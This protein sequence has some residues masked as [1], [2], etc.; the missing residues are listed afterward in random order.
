MDTIIV[1]TGATAIG[2]TSY[3]IRYAEEQA[4]EIISADS[5]QVYRHMDIGTAKPSPAELQRVP[6]HLV[7]IIDPDT[8]FSVA[9][10]V[11]RFKEVK[12]LL[13]KQG[14][15]YLVVGGTG[16]YL[17]AL[18]EGFNFPSAVPDNELRQELQD[19]VKKHDA[20]WL[21]NK[22]KELDP[23][24]AERLHP[25]DHFRLIRALEVVTATGKPL[26]EQQQKRTP[27]VGNY[28]LLCLTAPREVIYERINRRVDEMF[29]RGLVEEVQKLLAM[30]YNKNLMSLQALGYKETI[31]HLAGKY[32]RDELIELVKKRT[33]NFAKRQ[34]TWFRSFRGLEYIEIQ[35]I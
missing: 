6:H 3:A 34:M 13:E 26:A 9:D 15:N 24:T 11:E 17:R 29:S 27:L 21:H 1:I 8:P 32:G 19:G 25:N 7:N 4:A 18:L 20:N 30:G 16:L 12:L 22:L 23:A 33:R 28:R 31:E 14:K 10:Y 5:M 35:G 2:K